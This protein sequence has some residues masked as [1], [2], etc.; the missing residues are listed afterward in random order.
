MF[1]FEF[2]Y[3][4]YCFYIEILLKH[5]AHIKTHGRVSVAKEGNVWYMWVIYWHHKITNFSPLCS[6]QFLCAT[7]TQP[8]ILNF[9][10]MRLVVHKICAPRNCTMFL[11]FF[12]LIL[13]HTELKIIL[14]SIKTTFSCFDFFQICLK[15]GGY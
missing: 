11:V 12:V 3:L 10:E 1:E 2:T 7:Y 4:S 5:I 15:C 13:L 6:Y 14:K 8:Y 9:I